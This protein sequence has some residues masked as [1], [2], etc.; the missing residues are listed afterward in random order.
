MS[1]TTMQVDVINSEERGCTET[2]WLLSK[3]T[4]SFGSY[5]NLKR[6]NFGTLR[7]FNDD[8]VQPGKGFGTHTHQNMEII[9]IVLDGKLEHKDSKGNEGTL[10]PGD[11]QRMTAGSGIEHSEYNGS[12]EDPAR[13]LQI[14]VYPKERNLEPS[15]EQ[16]NIALEDNT[17][18]QIVSERPRSEALTIHQ[19]ASFFL[20]TFDANQTIQHKIRSKAHGVYIFLIGGEV[21]LG[22]KILKAGDSAQITQLDTLELQTL[23]KAKLLLIEVSVNTL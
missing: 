2:E 10:E 17:L 23:K 22:D 18:T 14:W 7:V 5:H 13:F 15:Y 9:T 21:E 20:G 3:H 16:K 4:Y 11:I 19:D 1:Y 12:K 6:L 8:I